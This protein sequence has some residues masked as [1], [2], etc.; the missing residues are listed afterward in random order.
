MRQVTVCTNLDIFIVFKVAAAFVSQQIQWAVAKQTI[1]FIT[2]VRHGVTGE[3]IALTVAEKFVTVVHI[4]DDP[5]CYF[6]AKDA[7]MHC[8]YLQLYH[9]SLPC[10]QVIPVD[11]K[12]S[13]SIM[14][15]VNKNVTR[16]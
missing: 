4:V 1:E 15:I 14:M 11:K 5:F 6:A 7:A 16:R 12:S 3:I 10:V 13:C 9:F 8:V 2:A